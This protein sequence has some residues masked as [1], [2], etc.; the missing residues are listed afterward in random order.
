MLGEIPQ[1]SP[2]FPKRLLQHRFTIQCQQV[3]GNEEEGAASFIRLLHSGKGD[4][5]PLVKGNDLAVQDERLAGNVRQGLR[6]PGKP[7][8]EYPPAP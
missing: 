7:L 5:P 3:K 1:S 6:E 8:I 2:P 4:M